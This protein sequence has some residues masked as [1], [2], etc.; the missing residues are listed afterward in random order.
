MRLLID[1][2]NLVPESGG[3]VHLKKTLENFSK[4]KFSK[5]IVISSEKVI[6]KLNIK[7]PKILFKTNLFLNKNLIFRIFWKIFILNF[8][9]KNLKSDVIFIL[10]GYFVI[11]PDIPTIILIQNLLPFSNISLKEENFFTVIKNKILKILHKYSI[12]RADLSVYL[13]RYTKNILK[14]LTDKYLIINHGVEKDFYKKRVK[15]AK[16]NNKH[17][18]KIFKI[19]YLSKYEKYKNHINLVLACEFLKNKGY[20]LSLDLIGVKNKKFEKTELF[21]KIKKINS[22]HKDL[23]KFSKLKNHKN[24]KKILKNY[25]L[26]VYPS[27]CESFGIII[28]ETIASSLPIIS[29]NYPVFRE[30]LKKN[31]IYFNP[32][33]HLDISKKILMYMNNRKIRK[34]NTIKLFR[35]SK[36]YKWNLTC[37]KTYLAIKDQYKKNI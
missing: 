3:F 23:I 26:H 22:K 9:V 29:S 18:S 35:L 1:A 24:I 10:G 13:S 8:T 15:F 17:G 11:K 25:D 28:L 33:N 36:N 7:D 19:L 16:F 5:I 20:N 14:D 31:S 2:S 34:K 6:K 12:R 32:Y 27:T 37:D 30:I 21:T 4:K